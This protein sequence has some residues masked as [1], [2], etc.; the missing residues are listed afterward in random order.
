MQIRLQIANAYI[1]LEDYA[2]AESQFYQVLRLK[3]QQYHRATESR[4]LS[5]KAGALQ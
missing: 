4:A 5:L 3:P 1:Q 2:N